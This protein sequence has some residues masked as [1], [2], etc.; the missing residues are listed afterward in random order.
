MDA[1]TNMSGGVGHGVRGASVRRLLCRAEWMRLGALGVPTRGLRTLGGWS[2]AAV[3]LAVLLANPGTA[4]AGPEGEQVSRGSVSFVR[5]GGETIITASN[6]S[7]INYRSFDI[8]ANE[9][10]RFIQPDA[11]SRVLNRINSAAPTRI[12]GGLFAN[13]RVYIV[14]PSGVIFGR[15]AVVDV[16]GLHAAAGRM[17]DADFLRGTDRFTN[18]SGQVINQGSITG[19][20]VALLGKSVFNAGSI[21]APEGTVVMAAGDSVLIGPREGGLM[22]RVEGSAIVGEGGAAVK[23]DGTINT[24]G[25]TGG[26][27][28]GRVMMAA[29]DVWGVALG[30]GASS[31][32][33]SRDVKIE[34][35]GKGVV[36][37]RGTIDATNSGA[38]SQSDARTGSATNT[39]KGGDVRVLGEYVAID[40]AAIDA[41]GATGGGTVLVGGNYLGQGS[42]RNATRTFV[43]EN[44]EIRADAT[45]NGNGGRVILWSNE[46]TWSLGAISARG[47]GQGRGGFVETSSKGFL[48]IRTT[49]DVTSPSGKGGTWLIDPT[50]VN[51][52]AGNGAGSMVNTAGTFNVT[53]TPA[54]SNLGVD[55]ITAAL[56]GGSTVTINTTSG[57]AGA[58]DINL[59]TTLD[60][61]GTGAGTLILNAVNDINFTSG[62][63]IIDSDT[64]TADS[65]NL[66]LNAG[67]NVDID[68]STI[69]TRGGNFISNGVNFTIDNGSATV[70]TAG[71]VAGSGGQIQI[72]HTGAVDIQR[73]LNS[74]GGLITVTGSTIGLSGGSGNIDAGAGSATLTAGDAFTIANNRFIS[75]DTAISIQSGADGG[76]DDISFGGNGAF[77]Q[78]ASITLRAG[79]GGSASVVDFSGAVGGADSFL[80]AAGAGTRPTTFNVIQ[81]AAITALVDIGEF[82]ASISGMNYGVQS[83]ATVLIDDAAAVA[84]A[85]LTLNGATSVTLD[86]ATDDPFSVG[87]LTINGTDLA[88]GGAFAGGTVSIADQV[89]ATGAFV[90]NGTTFQNTAALSATGF[91]L[92]HSGTIDIDANVTATGVGGFVSDR[93]AQGADA[94]D[95]T[96]F[97]IN[98][99]TGPVTVIAPSQGVTLG[100]I[101]NA[102]AITATGS[103]ITQTGTVTS[104]T[105]YD[106]NGGSVAI[107]GAVTVSGAFTSDGTTF[108]N[109]AALSAAGF[110]LEH[111]GNVDIDANVTATGAGG[112]ASNRTAETAGTFDSDGVTIDANN[113]NVA[114]VAPS[115]TVTLGQIDDGAAVNIGGAGITTNG[116]IGAGSVDLQSTAAVAVNAAITTVGAGFVSAG[117]TFDSVGAGDINTTAGSGIIDLNHTGA[118]NI[119]GDLVGGGAVT[120]DAGTT[121]V[122]G[123]TS[124]AASSVA[125]NVNGTGT[126]NGTV[127][128]ATNTSIIANDGLAI[129]ANVDAGNA[130]G[131]T[132]RLAASADGGNDN[133]SFGSDGVLLSGNA[134]FLQAGNGS[135]ST[136]VVDLSTLGAGAT[137][138]FLNGNGGATRPA[139]LTI[140]QDASMTSSNIPAGTEFG[141]ATTGLNL[142]LQSSGGSIL[143]DDA[144]AV[145]GVN[146]VLNGATGVTLDEGTNATFNV[147]SLAL[148]GINPLTTLAFSGTTV[149]ISDAINATG[150]LTSSGTTFQNTATLTASSIALEH[151][152]TIDIDANVT[153]T[154]VGG[155]ISDRT[156][157]TAGA[158]N[159]TGFTIDGGTG[160]VTIIA[161][162]QTVT[163]GAITNAGAITLTGS[164]ITQTGN[165]TS[166]TSYDAN[167]GSVAINGSVDVSGAFTSDGTTFAN[168]GT[169]DAGSVTLEHSGTI[170][171]NANVTVTGVGGFVSNRASETSGTFNSSL[172]TIDGGTG[173]VTVITNGSDVILGA[174]TN[175]GAITA[176]GLTVTQAGIVSSSASYAATGGAVSINTAV[177]VTGAFSSTGTTFNNG[178]TINADSVT[179][180][181][182]GNI[183][184]NADVTTGA[185]GFVS[186]RTAQASGVFDSDGVTINAGTGN[187]TVI[188]AVQDVLMGTISNAATI[189]LSGAAVSQN[190]TATGRS[191]TLNATNDASLNGD[192][193]ANDTVTP[194]NSLVSINAGSDGTGDVLGAAITIRGQGISIRAGDGAGGT[195]T[196]VFQN[197]GVTLADRT[198]TTN[199]DAVTIRQDAS[200][201]ASDI[202][203]LTTFTGGAVNGMTYTLQ[204]DAGSV[205]VGANAAR[206]AGSRLTLSALNA[207]QT[208]AWTSDLTVDS[209]TVNGAVPNLTN[210]VV[211]GNGDIVLNLQ[212]T[213]M[214]V[215]AGVNLV[216]VSSGNGS[217]LIDINSGAANAIEIGTNELTLRA[218]EIDLDGLA[219]GSITGGVG[220]SLRLEASSPTQAINVGTIGSPQAGAL[221]LTAADLQAIAS[222]VAQ[223]TIGRADGA[224]GDIVIGDATFVTDT[225][226]RTPSGGL[227]NVVGDIENTTT[228]AELSF[229]GNTFLSTNGSITTANGLVDF[230]SPIFLNSALFVIDTG[231]ATGGGSGSV[232][233]RQGGNLAFLGAGNTLRLVTGAVTL[234]LA[235]G[236]TGNNSNLDLLPEVTNGSISVGSGVGVADLA[237]GASV[238]TGLADGFGNLNLGTAGGS[239]AV[240]LGTFAI[241]DPL[242][243][244]LGA[245]GSVLISGTVSGAASAVGNPGSLTI[246]S[247]ATTLGSA[248]GG[249][250]DLLTGSF[251]LNGPLTVD[252][253]ASR[254]IA[255]D[256]GTIDLNGEVD[257]SGDGTATL[258]LDSGA[259]DIILRDVVGGNNRFLTFSILNARDVNPVATI[260]GTP[261]DINAININQS[262]GTGI[263]R[264]GVLNAGDVGPATDRITLTGTQF[265]FLGAIATNAATNSGNMVLTNSGAAT[266]GSAITLNGSFDQNGAGAVSLGANIDTTA[267]N[268][269]ITFDGP[270]T[271]TQSS[272][273]NAGTGTI[274][275]NNTLDLDTFLLELIADEIDFLGGANS[276]TGSTTATLLLLPSASGVSIGVG[277]GAGTL[278]ISDVD[279]LA[280]AS[281]AMDSL[282]IGNSIT[283]SH[284][285]TIG[286][287]G[288]GALFRNA[289]S[290]RSPGGNITVDGTITGEN[291]LTN[292]GFTSLNPVTLNAGI[293]TTGGFISISTDVQLGAGLSNFSN[294]A[295]LD[296]T[297]AGADAAGADVSITGT[298]EAAVADAQGI[299]INAGTDGSIELG[300]DIGSSVGL[301]RFAILNANT[302]NAV[303]TPVDITAVTI[304]QDAGTGESSFADLNAGSGG[305]D[306]SANSFLI[307]GDIDSDGAVDIDVAN[308]QF[309]TLFGGPRTFTTNT[310]GSAISI[311]AVDGDSNNLTISSAGNVTLRGDVTDMNA[312]TSSGDAF[313][314]NPSAL[315]TTA[316]TITLTHTGDVNLNGNLRTTAL[317]GVINIAAGTDD[318]GNVLFGEGVSLSS[319]II[320]L[321]A[322]NGAGGTNLAFVDADG[323]TLTTRPTFFNSANDNR[324]V[325]FRLQQDLAIADAGL[326]DAS[327]F[328]GALGGVT[329][330]VYRLVTLDTITIDTA[331]KVAGANLIL[332]A[333]NGITV[334]AALA[335]GQIRFNNTVTLNNS[336]DTGGNG[337]IQ[338]D[339]GATAGANITLAAGDNQIIIDGG[340]FDI[341]ANDVVFTAR[342]VQINTGA[343]VTGT[344]GTLALQ[345]D[346]DGVNI[347]IGGASDTADFDITA[348]EL[349]RL[350]ATGEDRF[351]LLTIG[352]TAG[353][354]TIFIDGP[355]A[356]FDPFA[357]IMNGVGGVISIDNALNARENATASLTSPTV[358]MA[359]TLTSQG[360]AITIDATTGV[361]LTAD[362]VAIDSTDSGGFATGA[363]IT[364]NASIDSDDGS[365]AAPGNRDFAINAGSSGKVFVQ[366]A[367]GA[368]DELSTVTINAGNSGTQ[369]IDLLD[370]RT[371]GSQTYSAGE[372]AVNDDLT[373]LVAGAITI[374]GSLALQSGTDAD[375]RITTNGASASDDVTITGTIATEIGSGP[376]ELII[377]VGTGDILIGGDIGFNSITP[378][379]VSDLAFTG[380]TISI[381][382]VRTSGTQTY[383]GTTLI[384]VDGDSFG[385]VI[386]YNGPTRIDSDL[387]VTGTTS[388]SFNGTV[389]SQTGEGNDLAVTSPLTTFANNL[390]GDNGQ[391]LELG[392]LTTDAAGTTVFGQSS[393]AISIRTLGAQTFG[394]AVNL[395]ANATFTSV[396][397]G[398]AFDSTVNSAGG[399]RD[400]TINTGSNGITRFGSIVGNSGVLTSVTTNADG[401]VQFNGNVTTTGDQTY[402]DAAILN[403]DAT[404]SG[405]AISFASGIDSASTPNDLTIVATS[406]ANIGADSGTGVGLR[407]VLITAPTVT[408]RSVRT[409]NSQVYNGATTLNGTLASVSS[410]SI[411][412]NGALALSGNSAI[413]TSGGSGSDVA[414]TGAITG[415]GFNL[416]LNAGSLGNLTLGGNATGLGALT[417]AGAGFSLNGSLGFA[418]NSSVTTTGATG[419]SITGAITG[420]GSD[421][422][423][424]AGSLGNLT[425]GGN[426]TGL[427]ALTARGATVTFAD[428]DTAGNTTIN[429][430]NFTAGAN[431]LSGGSL[432]IAGNTAASATQ[433]SLQRARAVTD[434]T[435]TAD[436]IIL[437]GNQGSNTS[438]AIAFNGP[439]VLETDVTVDSGAGV[440]FANTVD[441]RANVNL[442]NL[443]VNTGN[444]GQTLFA[445]NVGGIR[446]LANL[447]T[448][449]DGTTRFNGTIVNTNSDQV[450]NDAVLVAANTVF[451]GNDVAF[452]S[453]L[454]PTA[455]GIDLNVRT[456]DA[457]VDAGE[458]SFGGNVGDTTAFRTITTQL[459]AGVSATDS[460]NSATVLGGVMRATGDI[461]FFQSV[462]IA[463]PTTIASSGG[464][465]SFYRRAANGSVINAASGASDSSLTILSG[466]TASTTVTPIRFNGSVGTTTNRLTSLT[467]GSSNSSFAATTRAIPNVA[468]IVFTDAFTDAGEIV[469]ANVAATDA[470][471]VATGAGGF[472]MS[473]HEKLTAF[474]GITVNTLG[475]AFV[476]DMNA[477]SNIRIDATAITLRGRDSGSVLEPQ[478]GIL[479]NQTD[480]GL[481]FVADQSINFNAPTTLQG[482]NNA[483][484]A[485]S[486]AAAQA[487]PN[488][489]LINGTNAF[490]FLRGTFSGG[491]NPGFFAAPIGALNLTPLDLRSGGTNTS[492]ATALAG[493]IPRDQETRQVTTPVT[494]SRAL[495]EVLVPM[496]I[497]LRDLTDEQIVTFL[498]GRS[499]YNDV[500][501]RVAAQTAA[502]FKVTPNRLSNAGALRA[503]AAYRALATTEEVGEDGAV[504]YVP[505]TAEVQTTLEESWYRYLDECDKTQETPTGAGWRRW[506]ED[507]TAAGKAEEDAKALESLNLCREYFK[508]LEELNLSPREVRI[509]RD[510]II[511]EI[512]PGLDELTVDEFLAAVTGNP[513][514]RATP[515][516]ANMVQPGEVQPESAEVVG[517]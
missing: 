287:A 483:S 345:P 327:Q 188:A 238:L 438:G 16:A 451:S 303:S 32:I 442:R 99:G 82:G 398:V 400:L 135:G 184:I 516:P 511:A 256:S 7:V 10:V 165:V 278:D 197:L 79:N 252:D 174:I 366:G 450:Y 419:I 210:T 228:D 426:A 39:G 141:A 457:G 445:G 314:L 346:T 460:P 474:G 459:R 295:V 430:T 506:L 200:I 146:L 190:G 348:D 37:V 104:S 324:P 78:S 408:L 223:L 107:N 308:G 406:A 421:L 130:A 484:F 138:S 349:S 301:L 58:G 86:E 43:S 439:V 512:K 347:R 50:T 343:S 160:P 260:A 231:S 376:R 14:N 385:T 267:G 310:P 365:Q 264:F 290:F 151:S 501:Q 142:N 66:T 487:N 371:S 443:T 305:V 8:A 247:P 372:V 313:T 332:T 168:G 311:D 273:Q 137:A 235:N 473:L 120:V 309:I 355:S 2:A 361:L 246:T 173:P 134:I 397:A 326:P 428:I 212:N 270:V 121:T 370:V 286:T 90:S 194:A 304:R 472:N 171:I 455:S 507:P 405:A 515:E 432:T 72:N 384:A 294:V 149:L 52:I 74:D 353:T 5:S 103:A 42:E 109:T 84:G 476:S 513:M 97:T 202:P 316:N 302:V 486:D 226:V 243:I 411:S 467:L 462:V 106:A 325:D 76:D 64:G 232:R 131:N 509:P 297:N 237:V 463:A 279:L 418:G 132:V 139:T 207:G 446:E 496:G 503:I 423:L 417:A 159:S 209:L 162:S 71:A 145:N 422:T 143:L 403:S 45:V 265:S 402:N 292:V 203:L 96:G 102:G 129:N 30:T 57:G 288:D 424:N 272:T 266:I 335:P 285:I 338:F 258:T 461:N 147:S 323:S 123:A 358:N 315:I 318:T 189:L 114:I 283:G 113:G 59:N 344:G 24:T 233:V 381:Q 387:A 196:A 321:A 63:D 416:D 504:T 254:S 91:T 420:G 140:V 115:Q 75:A 336:I 92:E 12:D 204:S 276:V 393:P 192:I 127:G 157:E 485:V 195:N 128:S 320:V 359:S 3:S 20:F 352:R 342:D 356:I 158:F 389:V 236:V 245:G 208:V 136:A 312:F 89:T 492:V 224:H 396:N 205:D 21:N 414:V 517:G 510:R 117:T 54:S 26:T 144:T 441:T 262:A 218:T 448:N 337:D 69:N 281:G 409:S 230:Q 152:G 357:L 259:G 468:S 493:A 211:A 437:A 175:A 293:T 11:A 298:I 181:H 470:F 475:A 156:A 331:S 163:A 434:Q 499:L 17:S 18:M 242:A 413:S 253:A 282:L 447:T 369:D 394:D 154:G 280:F 296:T 380:N 241:R 88:V 383:D 277:G 412:V 87:S 178:G 471:T 390:G 51:I 122:D 77:L 239:H 478:A 449:A 29:G 502:D 274:A 505:R 374:N 70:D 124:S 108:Q 392:T 341:G 395:A 180:E 186:D 65:L 53:G 33:T 44:A 401:T 306:L 172:A 227:I 407:N 167:G 379:L 221:D 40:G 6:N 453:S 94:F 497:S 240:E 469:A 101:T 22:V 333:G 498:V 217:G 244:D 248:G 111:S 47:A 126:F 429:A 339:D 220:S 482:G 330:M 73:L 28:G 56:T 169:I 9:T 250:I 317:S 161:P 269:D 329:P 98:G 375:T 182:S 213:L 350:T 364:I 415:G 49:P 404:F 488:A 495:Q 19:D 148:N 34:G 185:G 198:G 193:T 187:V 133:L 436:T 25:A 222:S 261:S 164:A 291:N 465:V 170:G 80:G 153:A 373:S 481:D 491:V 41:S 27:R 363:D 454:N 479:Q 150:A 275:F 388:V 83:D 490:T 354:A 201:A 13:G 514:A 55:L 368:N 112:F 100:A 351:S 36:E 119:A 155:F 425:L 378:D 431:L 225:L 382:A 251:T 116:T 444:N 177:T 199:P 118:A 410:G 268:G 31:R 48:D 271:M 328:G 377:D 110:T 367:I 340:D 215:A 284:D 214:T 386:E 81:D 319:D 494:V 464:S 1:K 500:P 489:I 234:D 23:N 391:N 125:F 60:F 477:I 399:A 307:R 176:T 440:T 216:A 46:A 166:S 435:V 179:L 360:Q 263:S 35:Q 249:A 68:N 62:N 255:T 322:G 105:S 219:I 95:S 67:G 229:I 206:L 93:T 427:G 362:N 452:A 456:A 85:N 61:D 508:R 458:A 480:F 183:D 257:S 4:M 191:Y 289:V 38:R 334:N 300:D 299:D 466:A 15:N 433:V